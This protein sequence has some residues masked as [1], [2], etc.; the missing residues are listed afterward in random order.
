VPGGREAG[1]WIAENVPE[2]AIFL[3][4]GPSMAN[5]IQFYGHRKAYGLSVSPNPLKRNPS[6]EAIENPDQKI[7]TGE[8]QYLVFDSFSTSRSPF[9][10][11]ALMKYAERYH[12]VIVHSEYVTITGADGQPE[13]LPVIVIYQV[14]P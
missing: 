11:K 2:G 3:T 10:G 7:R 14:R 6:Y 4:V 12:G 13:Q 1:A 8:L 9:F 5:I